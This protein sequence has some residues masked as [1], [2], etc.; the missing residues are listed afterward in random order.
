MKKLSGIAAGLA[1]AAL[2]S[3]PLVASAAPTAAVE[4]AWVNSAFS[5][6]S[7]LGAGA[8]MLTAA[9]LENSTGRIAPLALTFAI[10]GFDVAL[11]GFYWGIYVPYYGGGCIAG[12]SNSLINQH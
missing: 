1:L 11:M 8:E 4:G 9:E 2:I 7:P 12:C 3:Q 5:G 6:V 10:A